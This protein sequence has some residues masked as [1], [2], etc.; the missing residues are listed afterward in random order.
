MLVGNRSCDIVNLTETNVWCETSPALLLPGADVL[1]VP[2]PVEVWT[3]NL[4]F[5]RGPAPSLVGKDFT[6]TYEVATTP[7]VTAV[8]GEF[9]NNSLS[10]Y[11]EG[12]N[13]SNS[14]VL[15]GGLSCDLET[16]S[17]RSNMSLS[18][19]SF[20]LHSLEAGVYPLRV[21]QKQ[22]GFANMS[23]VPQ[24]FVVTPRILAIF[25][26]DGSACGGTVLT[27]RGVALNSRRRS[28]QVDLSGPF[29]CVILSS[30]DQTVLCQINLVGDS[31]P[32]ASFTLNVT[33]LVNGLPS[34]CQGE[35]TLSLREETTPVVDALT[36]NISGSLTSVLIRGRR[37]G[38]TA[39]EPMVYLDDHLP[40]VVTFFNASHV[41]C[42]IHDLTPGLHYLSVFH[43]RNGYACSGNIS[44]HFYVLP[45][46]FHYFPKNF[47]I[48]GGG[49]LT[50]E[51]TA[52]RGQNSTLVYIGQQA[53]LTVNISAELIQ[54]IVP[55]GNGSVVLGVEVDGRSYQM[56]VIGYS[57]TFTPELLSVSHADDVLTFVVAQISGAENVDIFIGMS[58][59][60]GVSGNHTVLQCMTPVL[61]AGEY[62]VR[63]YD[64]ARGWASSDLVLTWRATITAVTDN[65]GKPSK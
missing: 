61:A 26:A 32:G 50:I 39:D 4:S 44:R 49:L 16:Q 46:V 22:M 25:P 5:T 9:T 17:F 47:S 27:V 38:T 64:H 2:V 41:A 42:S 31:V 29:T 8:R 62:R 15:L 45:Q 51:G 13:L 33:V 34:E 58:A 35:C 57:N 52:L 6:F 43:S 48:H 18:G 1:T 56:G 59:C 10:L 14:V 37:L 11:V 65:F 54:C 30:G 53:C 55:A 3:G 28:V 36:I 23:V 19:C 12:K 21:R 60:V 20:P 63:G 40:C 7:V 24:Q